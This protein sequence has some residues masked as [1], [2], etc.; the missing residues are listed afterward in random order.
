MRDGFISLPVL[1]WQMEQTVTLKLN[2]NQFRFR[3]MD[4]TLSVHYLLM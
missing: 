1:V 4:H 3:Q 2:W